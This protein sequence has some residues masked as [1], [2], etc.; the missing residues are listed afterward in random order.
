MYRSVLTINTAGRKLLATGLKPVVELLSNGKLFSYLTHTRDERTVTAQL[1]EISFFF[2]A[3]TDDKIT[4]SNTESTCKS[5][6][7]VFFVF[8]FLYFCISVI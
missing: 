2:S 4:F 6:K 7:L 5:S 8:Y 1:E 3:D